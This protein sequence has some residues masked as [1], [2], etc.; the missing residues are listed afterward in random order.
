MR[1]AL[2]P[3]TRRGALAALGATVS[4]VGKGTLEL[5]QT[6][7]ANFSVFG[8]CLGSEAASDPHNSLAGGFD[9]PYLPRC[10]AANA[11]YKLAD[12]AFIALQKVI[13]HYKQGLSGDHCLS[14][15]L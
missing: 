15:A 11:D 13:S 12:P 5:A 2:I 8:F 14:R 1:K 6:S 3:S 7:D 10:N 9:N 4:G